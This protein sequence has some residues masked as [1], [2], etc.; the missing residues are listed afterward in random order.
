MGKEGRGGVE[1]GVGGR[2]WSGGRTGSDLSAGVL[3]EAL[4]EAARAARAIAA[5]GR[6]GRVP[7]LR[8][9]RG[10]ALYPAIDPVRSLILT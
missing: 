5:G 7:V 9:S 6:E 8:R 2:A 10:H 3:P 4:A 1:Q